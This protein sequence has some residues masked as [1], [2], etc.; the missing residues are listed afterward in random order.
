MSFK[1]VVNFFILGGIVLIA[2]C[3]TIV[4]GGPTQTVH[5][6]SS[7]EGAKIFIGVVKKGRKGEVETVS[8]LD[9]G[10]KTP[11]NVVI[12]RKN[13]TV[14]LKKEGYQDATI[15]LVSGMNPWFMG[16][17]ITGGLIGSSIDSSTG[18]INEYNPGHYFVEL[19][20]TEQL[21]SDQ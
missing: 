7:P 2:G 13:V 15:S 9:S 20:P 12:N 18:A 14:V 4:G 1:T 6:T 5:F 17:F 10:L 19:K 8:L 21:P 16:N 11:S 3:A